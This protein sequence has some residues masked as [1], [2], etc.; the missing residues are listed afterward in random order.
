MFGKAVSVIRKLLP[1]NQ[2]ARG[3]SVLVGGTAGSQLLMVLA[4]PLLTRLFSPED[5]GVLAVYAGL[6]ALFTVIASLRYQLA[7]PLPE[8]AQEAASVVVLCLLSV[9][10]ISLLSGLVVLFA[11]ANIAAWLGVPALADY[12]WLLPAGVLFAGVYQVFNY[13]AIRN[14]QFPAIASTRLKQALTMLSIQLAGY[15]LGPVALLGGQAA[16]QGVGGFQLGRLA[17]QQSQLRQ[18]KL[19]D[20]LVA[21]KRYRHFPIF[22]TWSG[23]F[24][25]A[26]QQMPPLMFAALFNPAAAGL[27][28]LAH[29]VLAMPMSVIGSAIGNVF[30]ANAAE[31]HREGR[32]APL[33]ASVHEKL[34]HI[35]MPPAIVLLVAGP[36]LFAMVFGPNWRSAGEFAQWMAPWL[37]MVFITSP[38]STLFSVLEKQRQGMLFQMLLFVVRLASIVIGASTGDLMTTVALFSLGSMLCWVGFLTWITINSGNAA[39]SLIKPTAT[40][41]AWAFLC[42]APLAIS[43]W[44]MQGEYLWLLAL[45][46]TSLLIAARFIYLLRKAY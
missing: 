46:S 12:F 33:V 42:A 23:L 32:L 26:G 21:A 27:Y 17:S 4:A 5:F 28:A 7:I 31:A 29:R 11:G 45:A 40:A 1:K 43:Q 16:G 14:K 13:W 15:K 8:D 22:S 18:V 20:V 19:S 34:A 25:T 37:Y 36:E 44:A 10:S 9:T 3:V 41:F 2:F 39:T 38:L 30:V 6:L 35:A 24:N